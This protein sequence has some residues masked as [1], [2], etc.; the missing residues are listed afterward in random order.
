M[1]RILALVI[2][3][4]AINLHAE[5]IP[6]TLGYT[7][8]GLNNPGSAVTPQ[9]VCANGCWHWEAS[10]APHGGCYN[11]ASCSYWGPGYMGPV[12]CNNTVYTCPAGQG[13]TL[14]G[15]NCV[16]ADCPAGQTRDAQGQCVVDCSSKIGTTFTGYITAS[17][18]PAI[19]SQGGCEAT[20]IQASNQ[21]QVAG[22]PAT[23]GV[24]QYT[25]QSDTTS[26]Q[27]TQ[28][29]PQA[30]PCPT[31]QCRGEVNGVMTCLAC[32]SSN[33]ATTTTAKTVINADGSK[34]I[35]MQTT[36]YGDTS[37]TTTTVTNYAP[38]GAQTGQQTTQQQGDTP[39]PE[40]AAN[41]NSVGCANLGSIESQTEQPDIR[42]ITIT[43]DTPW[44]GAGQCPADV[45]FNVMGH[46]VNFKFTGA[47]QF[48]TMMQ[49]VVLAAAWV[50]AIFLVVTG[51]RI[52]S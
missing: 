38:G 22:Q 45:A 50:A 29:Q 28:G 34:T 30:G 47:C 9:A 25:G 20:V 42:N 8:C 39:T 21:C 24:W 3:L 19:V 18:S 40:C 2:L 44:G 10:P 4:F 6:A 12:F 48:F 33:T 43:P 23:C 16:R 5:T 17:G 31:G 7:N 36:N 27:A 11:T 15:T 14:T 32:G 49:P 52:E 35:T 26:T 1:D 51:A 46:V 41:P 37:N 13:W